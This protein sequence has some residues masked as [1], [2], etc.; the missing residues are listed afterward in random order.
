[1]YRSRSGDARPRRGRSHA[2]QAKGVNIAF[3]VTRCAEQPVKQSPGRGRSAGI[4][5]NAIAPGTTLTERIRPRYEERPAEVRER[6]P[7]AKLRACARRRFGNP[8]PLR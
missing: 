6:D 5:V 4:N 8:V 3:V 1:M 7:A 2:E